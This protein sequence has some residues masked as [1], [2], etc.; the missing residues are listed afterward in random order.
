VSGYN[1]D[2]SGIV[3]AIGETVSIVSVSRTYSDRGAETQT[4]TSYS[5]KAVVQEMT[6]DDYEVQEGIM[7][8]GDITAFF[9]E[10]ASNVAYLLNDNKMTSMASLGSTRTY[11]I[12]NVIHNDGH[13]E[14]WA[15]REA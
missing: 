10:D 1:F 11:L 8:S 4:N 14:V 6:A 9:D 13:Y 3:G 15:S 12:K 2:I 5:S 7:Q